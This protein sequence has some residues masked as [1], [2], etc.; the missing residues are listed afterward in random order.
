SATTPASGSELW[1]TDGTTAGTVMVKDIQPGAGDAFDQAYDNDDVDLGNHWATLGGSV[2]FPANDG[3]TGQELW[4]SDGTAAG[5]V[6]LG[7]LGPGAAGSEPRWI[8]AVAGRIFFTADD[9]VHGRE[10]WVTDG[11]AA[12]T[13]LLADV[14]P[15]AGS[16]VPSE[17]HAVGT[18]LLF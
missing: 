8:T 10:L 9:G 3:V 11:T 7:D 5:T 4:I 15:G 13:H 16:S 17:L 18:V 2:V 6:S 14:E 12:G 1:K